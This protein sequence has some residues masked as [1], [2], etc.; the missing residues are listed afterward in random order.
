MAAQSETHPGQNPEVKR[1]V[2]LRVEEARTIAIE[3]SSKSQEAISRINKA[4]ENRFRPYVEESEVIASQLT[5][6]RYTDFMKEQRAFLAVRTGFVAC[7]DGRIVALALIDPRVGSGHRRLQGLPNVRES[8]ANEGEYILDDP[9]LAASIQDEFETRKNGRDKAKIVEFIGPHINSHEPTHGCGAFGMKVDRTGQTRALGMKNGGINEYFEELGEGFFAFNNNARLSGG[10]GTTFD[11]VH[12]AYSQGLIFGTRDT[13]N[14][15]DSGKSLRANLLHLEEEGKIIM[16]ETLDGNFPII[17]VAER[18]GLSTRL[19]VDNFEQIAT[20][21]ITI[22]KVARAIAENEGISWIPNSFRERYQEEDLKILSYY[23]IRNTV[24]RTLGNINLG[25]HSLLKHPEQLIRVG[26]IGAD[27]NVR[28]IPFIQ[29]TSDGHIHKE[30]IDGTLALYSLAGTVLPQ[31]GADLTQEG[32]I[33]ITTGP[34][35]D[36]VSKNK[37]SAYVKNNAAHIRD[38]I[39]PGVKSG[40]AVVIGGLYESGTKRLTKVV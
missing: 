23:A 27:F 12:D 26:P 11:V 1:Q 16:T 15:F 9:D 34:L 2:D 5:S 31:L 29:N 8:T 4:I 24:Y 13:Y 19:N 18:L 7:P 39:L 10:E 38:Q 36:G 14:S 40:E 21:A 35:E 3:H 6:K 32:R 22:G 20:N 17:E 28:N 33:I 37:V 30:D 25:N